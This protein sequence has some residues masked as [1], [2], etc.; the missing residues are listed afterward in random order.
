MGS[1][2]VVG[3]GPTGLASAMLLA[4]E[5]HEVTI[6]EK[7]PQSS[8]ATALEAWNDWER[9][10]VA[11]FRQAHVMHARFRHTLDAEFPGV[12]DDIIASGG[13]RVSIMSGFFK[14]VDRSVLPGDERFETLTARRPVVES[15]FAR[16]AE[17]T[18]GVRVLRGVS[19]AGPVAEG[20]LAHGIPHVVGVRTKDGQTY[21][22]D[23]VIDAMGRKSPFVE[24]MEGIGARPPIEEK[25]DMGFAYYTRHYQCRDG[26]E[27]ELRRAPITTLSTFVTASV[28]ADNETW[29]VAV[30]GMSGDKPLKALRQNDVWE[31]VVRSV[32]HLSHWIE[33]DPL[34]D[35]HPMAGGL[36]RYRRFVVDEQPV[37]TGLVAVGD[38]WTCTN[39]TAGRGISLG[40]THAVALR[41]V[42]R[43]TFDDP[44]GL[45]LD[46]DTVTEEKFTPWY[47]QQLER[48]FGRVATI[49]AAIEGRDPPKTDDSNPIARVQRAF[50]TAAAYDAECSRAFAEVFSVLALPQEIMARP[51][52]IE[53][54]MAAAEGRDMPETPGPTRE[55]VLKVIAGD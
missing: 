26:F 12:R 43:A 7:D 19:V 21:R 18:P 11:Q 35:V 42:A 40:L 14:M 31:R 32:P 9:T 6:L 46:L 49:T 20:S 15:A 54:V 51:G 23:L 13:R 25:T 37:V 36:D 55:E 33:G 5:G 30:I 1:V 38:S 8:P 3:G 53:K 24:W 50:L 28:P 47:R 2:I 16:A 34:H 39:P 10:G 29:V 48:D 4:R 45:A 44:Y 27:P 52:M 17:N 41:D 22:A